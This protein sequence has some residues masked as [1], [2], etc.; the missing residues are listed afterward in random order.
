MTSPYV[1]FPQQPDTATRRSAPWRV[2]ATTV[3]ALVGPPSAGFFAFWATVTWTGC[4]IDCNEATDHPNPVGG[5]L[6]YALAIALLLS[7]P[8]LAWLLLRSGKAVALTLVVPAL[9]VL[10]F[11]IG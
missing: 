2:A 8:V 7:G 5:G 6:L 4:F 1:T 11:V 9:I 3:M 10:Y